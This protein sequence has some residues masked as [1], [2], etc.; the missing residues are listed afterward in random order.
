[1]CLAN[2]NKQFRSCTNT[3]FFNTSSPRSEYF[4]H[5]HFTT[6]LNSAFQSPPK[7]YLP[8]FQTFLIIKVFFS[9]HVMFSYSETKPKSLCEGFDY[10]K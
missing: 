8:Q 9:T 7:K 4:F 1:M 3:I 6:Q 5:F 2:Y 10:L